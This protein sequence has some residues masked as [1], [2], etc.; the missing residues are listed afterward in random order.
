MVLWHNAK[1]NG[2]L[3]YCPQDLTLV[4]SQPPFN[5]FEG[6]ALPMFS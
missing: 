5:Q 4:F 2:A 1:Q 3:L 6:N